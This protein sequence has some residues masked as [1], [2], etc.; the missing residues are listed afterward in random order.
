[1]KKTMDA[2][3]EHGKPDKLEEAAA[4]ACERVQ[5]RPLD[6]TRFLA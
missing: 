6:F 5:C 4:H 1:M 2:I 3:Y